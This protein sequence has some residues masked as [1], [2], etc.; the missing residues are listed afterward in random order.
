M[1]AEGSSTAAAKPSHNQVLFW[2]CFIALIT[3]SFAFVGRLSLLNVWAAEFSLDPAETGRLAGIGIWPFAVSIIGFSLFIDRI[4]YK[5][6]MIVAFI[7]HLTWTVMAVTAYYVEDKEVGFQLLYWG[8]LIVSLANGSVEAFINPVVATMFSDAKTK[9]LNIL[10]AGWPAGLVVTGLFV[11][12]VDAYDAGAE[13][14]TP[15]AVKV[16]VIGLPTLIYFIMLIGQSFPE[17]ERVAAGV[18][19]RDMLREFGIGGALV[20]G[21]L[22][23]LQ[24]MDFFSG[25]DTATLA[26]WQKLMF[27]G[28]G[29]GVVAAFGAYTRS[30]GN[31]MLLFL[32]LIMMPLATTEIGTDGWITAIMEGAAENIP[33]GVPF[34]PAMVLVYTS[35][36]MLVL[37]FFAGPLVHLVSPLGLLAI[38]AILAIGGLTWLS[39]AQAIGILGAATL[40]GVG[41]TFFWPTMLGVVSEQC[42]RGGAF[43]LN[44]ISG[45]GMLAVGTLG[46]PYIGI[47]QSDAQ[48]SA[49][50]ASEE[51]NE[52]LPGLVENDKLQP[53]T[54][55][56]SYEVL[57]YTAIDD[58]ALTSLIEEEAGSAEAATELKEKVKSVRD[59]SNQKALLTMAAFPTFMLVCYLIL[60]IYFRTKGGY[61]AEVLTHD[62]G[63]KADEFAGGV[64]AAVE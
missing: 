46:F 26:L 19:Y 16:G 42:P 51:L 18:S 48:K 25:G 24:L 47:L 59:R 37:R 56:A 4:G 57:K 17:S 63:E 3:T 30:I 61:K 29:V 34:H 6:A 50:V 44:A 8:S 60:V 27:I 1:S 55:K 41:K 45:I 10:H 43:T 54:P 64:A 13:S 32:I 20:V 52:A 9:W 7:G 58:A 14:V 12:G 36:I 40:Y 38:S 22:L 31:P 49:L 5:T 62:P 23:T 11:M 39:S 2:G 35:A 28:I 33:E 53:V 21:F 15:W